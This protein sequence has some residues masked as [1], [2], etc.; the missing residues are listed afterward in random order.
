[1][2]FILFFDRMTFNLEF[3]FWRILRRS[4]LPKA[5]SRQRTEYRSIKRR[6]KRKKKKKEKNKKKK[7]M[8]REQDV[9]LSFL[10]S[11]NRTSNRGRDPRSPLVLRKVRSPSATLL[12]SSLLFYVK[13]FRRKFL[14]CSFYFIWL[15]ILFFQTVFS[16]QWMSQYFKFF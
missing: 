10:P 8:K 2:C 13:R 15:F 3:F 4:T 5:E 6:R 16:F 1:M 14:R 12:F 9:P 11:H 7:T